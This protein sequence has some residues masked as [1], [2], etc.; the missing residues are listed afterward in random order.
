MERQDPS[1]GGGGRAADAVDHLQVQDLTTGDIAFFKFPCE[2]ESAQAAGEVAALASA[3]ASD[4]WRLEECAVACARGAKG[5]GERAKMCAICHLA[6]RQSSLQQADPYA[7]EMLAATTPS[8]QQD[9][10]KEAN[11][12][13]SSWKGWEEFQSSSHHAGPRPDRDFSAVQSK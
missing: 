4:P 3:P 1:S 12:S 6:K 13:E 5:E 9:G 2:A 10:K 8:S 11:P 7:G